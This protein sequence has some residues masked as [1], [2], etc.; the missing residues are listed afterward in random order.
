MARKVNVSYESL[1]QEGREEVLEWL[2]QN[3]VIAYSAPENKYFYFNK[4]REWL[5]FL[6]WQKD[7]PK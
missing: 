5:L 6:P 7:Q 1:R 2:R 3:E 4:D